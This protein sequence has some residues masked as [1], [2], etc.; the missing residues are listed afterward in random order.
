MPHRVLIIGGGFGGLAAVKGLRRADVLVTVLDRRNFHLFQPLLY[1]VATG[2][3]SPANIAMPLRSLLKRQSNAE[4][5]L[6]EAVAVDAQKN[7]V[8]LADGEV[9]F[10]TLILAAGARHHYFG[11]S[12]FERFAP[13]LKSIEDATNIR[14]RI[15]TAFETA[16]R[17][18]DAD[19]IARWLTFVVVGGGPTGVELAGAIA[20]LAK[21]TLR[22]DYRHVETSTARILLVESRDHVLPTYPEVLSMRAEA[23]L[24]KLGVESR[25]GTLMED[26]THEGLQLRTGDRVEMLRTHN[27]FWSAGVQAAPLAMLVSSGLDVPTD[28]AGR[29]IVEPD[30]SL[31]GYPHIYAIGDLAHFADNGTDPLPAMAPVAVQQG[32]YVANCIAEKLKGQKPTAFRYKD[33]GQMATIGRAAAVVNFGMLRFGGFA[34]WLFWLFV[35]LMSLV[36]FENRLLVFFQW[37]W[38]YVTRNRSARLI[39]HGDAALIPRQENSPQNFADSQTTTTGFALKR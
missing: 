9:H 13:G 5:I 20:E 28:G 36:G 27:V 3:L 18:R 31:A 4:V 12:R 10:D 6:G 17:L 32:K 7:R 24:S 37:W 29:L 14:R 38:N 19:S 30:C 15:M 1:Q 11:N 23:A 35:H 22:R 21:H 34:A 25:T 2:G 39:T 16:E 8:L 33:W 26:I